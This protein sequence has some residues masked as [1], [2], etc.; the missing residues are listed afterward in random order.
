LAKAITAALVRCESNH[1]K[2]FLL[3]A[4]V[5]SVTCGYP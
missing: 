1:Y 3:I 2:K 5:V 4:H